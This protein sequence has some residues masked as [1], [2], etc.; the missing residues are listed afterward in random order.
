MGAEVFYRRLMSV[1]DD[2]GRYYAEPT[3]LLAAC[4]PRR[5]GKITPAELNVWLNEC[6]AAGLIRLYEF[7]EQRYLEMLK[8]N[9]R[10][11]A[12]TSKFPPI[13]GDRHSKAVHTTPV[14]QPVDCQLTDTC[15]SNDGQLAA[16]TETKTETYTETETTTE[17]D[18]RFSE[19]VAVEVVD[20]R[21][22]AARLL[23]QA[24]MISNVSPI[25]IS[26]CADLIRVAGEE[27]VKQGLATACAKGLGMPAAWNYAQKV[28]AGELAKPSMPAN[29]EADRK[30]QK[31]REA[32][33]KA[34]SKPVA[35]APAEDLSYEEIKRQADERF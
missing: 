5:I 24:G 35:A 26:Q 25:A 16:Y 18:R 28:V 7:E 20:H 22:K 9:Q 4:F 30:R 23:A 15:Q 2:Y 17:T 27:L 33:R 14:E 11:R 32:I 1:V 8:F 12:K 6:L 21:Q 31:Q 34:M 29:A 3:L 19:S 13:A 10:T